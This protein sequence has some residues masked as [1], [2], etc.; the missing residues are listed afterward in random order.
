MIFKAQTEWV[1]PSELP[2]LRHCDE[3][4]IDLETYDPDLKKLGTCSVIGRG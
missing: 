2:D 3:I 4:V 1:K